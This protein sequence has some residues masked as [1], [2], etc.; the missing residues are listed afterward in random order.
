MFAALRLGDDIGGVLDAVEVVAR[1]VA[2]IDRL[3][4][5]RDVL[6]GREVGGSHEIADEDGLAGGALL[7]RQLAGQHVDLPPADRHHIVER[8]P[9]QHGEFSLAAAARRRAR[10]RRPRYCRAA[11]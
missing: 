7:R 10:T 4:Q 6:L 5:E 11:Y 3:D 8:L 1:P 2:R 9:E